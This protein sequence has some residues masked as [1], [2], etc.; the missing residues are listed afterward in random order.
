MPL[1][2]QWVDSPNDTLHKPILSVLTGFCRQRL[3]LSIKHKGWNSRMEPEFRCQDTFFI[4]KSRSQLKQLWPFFLFVAFLGCFD[5]G[6]QP[7][8]D[9][10]I[11]HMTRVAV[12]QG[13]EETF[14]C[15]MPTVT[16]SSE[17]RVL[18]THNATQTLTH[19]QRHTHTHTRTY[20][21]TH[22]HVHMDRTDLHA[23][24]ETLEIKT[25]KDKCWSTDTWLCSYT[26]NI[27]IRQ[28]HTHTC[29][30]AL[31]YYSSRQT[32][33]QAEGV[34]GG[35]GGA[36]GPLAKVRLGLSLSAGC[37]LNTML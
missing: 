6:D 30:S 29:T 33:E 14:S 27:C 8:P 15:R 17:I 12:W 1:E 32:T 24:F 35:P 5:W 36:Y 19:R 22:T 4:T 16:T 18:G 23:C 25:Q 37:C 31:I 7:A 10:M 34:T 9:N 26:H 3:C 21:Y 28:T 2:I 20:T 13:E 11:S